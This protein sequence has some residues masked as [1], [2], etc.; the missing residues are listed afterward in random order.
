MKKILFFIYFPPSPLENQIISSTIWS[1]DVSSDYDCV[2]YDLSEETGYY[3]LVKRITLIV[4]A[5]SLDRCFLILSAGRGITLRDYIV[6]HT[7]C[8]LNQSLVIH[9][10]AN[11][12]KSFFNYLLRKQLFYGQK[13]ILADKNDYSM[14]KSYTSGEKIMLCPTVDEGYLMKMFTL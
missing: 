7:L 6:R 12:R 13:V 10:P 2:F 1:S 5:E 4:R 11:T 9:Y 14:V 3:E 8:R